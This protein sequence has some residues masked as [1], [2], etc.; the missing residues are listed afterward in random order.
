[1]RHQ[2]RHQMWK[3]SNFCHMISNF[4]RSRHVEDGVAGLHTDGELIALQE[5]D[6]TIKHPFWKLFRFS[7]RALQRTLVFTVVFEIKHPGTAFHDELQG[8][9]D[10]GGVGGIDVDACRGKQ[11]RH[12]GRKSVPKLTGF[13]FFC[14]QTIDKCCNIGRVFFCFPVCLIRRC[15]CSRYSV[16]MMIYLARII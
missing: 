2:A 15:C 14:S 16:W 12:G 9:H 6:N 4:S 5:F 7:T 13:S 3:N 8:R 10:G 11:G 1:V